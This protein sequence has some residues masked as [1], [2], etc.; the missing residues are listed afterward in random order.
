MSTQPRPDASFTYI[1]LLVLA[2]VVVLATAYAAHAGT[3]AVTYDPPADTDLAECR[4]FLQNAQG[5]A[6]DNKVVPA[7]SLTAGGSVTFTYGTVSLQSTQG[8]VVARCVD[9]AGN[10]SVDST[11][12]AAVF[13]DVAPGPPTLR[14]VQVTP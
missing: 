3:V 5:G 12:L 1:A 14:D 6:I 8:T 9:A 13:P 7:A 4:F 11:P 10:V 2:L